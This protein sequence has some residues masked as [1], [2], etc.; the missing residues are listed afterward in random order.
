MVLRRILKKIR[1]MVYRMVIRGHFRGVAMEG[2][3]DFK[4]RVLL[5]THAHGSG[6]LLRGELFV[7]CPH[8]STLL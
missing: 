2:S 4:R 6:S 1:K 8:S 3:C 5:L 7:M